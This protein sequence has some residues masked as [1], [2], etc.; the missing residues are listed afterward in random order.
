MFDTSRKILAS[1]ARI[2]ALLGTLIEGVKQAMADITKLSTA[3]PKF[4]GDFAQF[5][6][7]FTAFLQ[8]LPKAEDP[9]VQ[10]AIDGF[11]DQVTAMDAAVQGMDA[12]LKPAAQTQPSTDAPA[13][14]APA[15]TS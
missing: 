14:D 7:D 12:S 2:E 9:T 8:T 6:A 1:L 11:A 4:A 13:A 15:A 3:F 10:T 5:R